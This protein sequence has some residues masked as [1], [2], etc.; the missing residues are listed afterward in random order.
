LTGWRQEAQ[1]RAKSLGSLAVWQLANDPHTQ[2][3]CRAVDPIGKLD[4]LADLRRVCA[5]AIAE[6]V[7]R[8]MIR[9]CR[10]S[11]SGAVMFPLRDFK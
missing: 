7:D 5:E 2:A 3:V 11:T 8:R 6:A 4:L 10:A 1:R 9:G